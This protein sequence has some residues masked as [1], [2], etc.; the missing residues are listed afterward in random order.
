MDTLT[1]IQVFLKVA[2]TGNFSAASDL[3]GLSRAM[4]SKHVKALEDRLGVR[5]LNRTTRRVSLTEAGL[6]YLQRAGQA[7][8]DLEDA[9]LAVSD[10]HDNPRGV[11][12]VNAPMSFGI[13]HLGPALPDFLAENPELTVDLTLNDRYVD[14]VE[15]GYD[16]AV[17]I[18]Q[19]PDSSYIARKIAP[20]RMV[21]AAAPA[22]LAA[23]GTP[24][25]PDDL[26]RHRCLAYTYSQRPEFW[27]FERG[28]ESV[29]VRISGHMKANNGDVLRAAAVGGAGIIAQPTFLSGEDVRAG[30]LTPILCG[31][32]M[33]GGAVHAVYPPN[34]HVS[35][36]VRRF[37]DFLVRRFGPEPAWD[38][39]WL[40]KFHI[41]REAAE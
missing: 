2:E 30:R 33:R 17:R 16:V 29:T 27:S 36:K 8:A 15:E 12:K 32:T 31:W 23:H 5:L 6:A 21:A 19:L 38:R 3:L 39:E 22:Y 41:E 24:E 13:V 35:S 25:H 1:S 20:V 26:G 7:M 10:L 18:G 34:R 9:E 11:L 37:V 28:E 14:L 4:T 40:E